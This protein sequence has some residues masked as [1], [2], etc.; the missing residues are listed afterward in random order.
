MA[1]DLPIE[2]NLSRPMEPP[3]SPYA[4]C[5]QCEYVG[6]DIHLG[7]DCPACGA[8]Q[9]HACGM[10]PAPEFNELWDDIVFAWNNERAEIGAVVSAM[11]FEASVFDLIKWGTH[12]LDPELNW[13]GA[14]FEEVGE[15]SDRIWAYLLT[16]RSNDAT[17]DALKRLFGVDGKVMLQTAL[18]EEAGPFWQNYRC[19]AEFRNEIVH[20]GRR[21]R[22]RT[23]GDV[24][25][26]RQTAD[27]MLTASMYFVP[28]CW[29]VFSRLWNKYIHNEMLARRKAQC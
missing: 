3:V 9:A 26:D 24:A 10:W 21:V 12:W 4:T 19:L 18:G 5:G 14:A 22:Y 28:T 2:I 8:S 16:I 25:Q 13:I 11:Y 6:T 29:V 20:K 23:V 17:N 27:R 7:A 1:I 15:K